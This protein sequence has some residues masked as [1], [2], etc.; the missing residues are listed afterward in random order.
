MKFNLDVWDTIIISF[1]AGLLFMLMVITKDQTYV[2]QTLIEMSL[3]GLI[4]GYFIKKL[5]AKG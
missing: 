2:I 5:V 4:T 1:V 3:F